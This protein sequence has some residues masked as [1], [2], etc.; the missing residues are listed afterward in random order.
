MSYQA[1]FDKATSIVQNLPKGG[2]V[3]PTQDDQLFFYAR[4]KQAT[5]GDVNIPRPGMLDFT[6]KAKWDA[7]NEIK[8][9]S[10]EDAMK[11]YVEKLLKLLEGNDQAHYDELN[12]A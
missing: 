11:E 12:N 6:G 10:K 8:G 7:W 5:I 4:F 9:K 3:Q 2:P 1:K